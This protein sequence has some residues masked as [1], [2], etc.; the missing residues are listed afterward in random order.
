MFNLTREIRNIDWKVFTIKLL[1]NTLILGALFYFLFSFWEVIRQEA[2]FA[3]WNIRGQNFTVDEIKAEDPPVESPFAGLIRQP[4]PLKVTPESTQFGIV[5]EKIGV[6][7]PVIED[8]SVT[9]KKAYLAALENGVAHA[10][11][12]AKP[13]Q[14]GNAYLF[15][16]SALDFWN[17]GPYS[18][19]FNLL[20]K[21]EVGDRIVIFYN[22]Q[23]FDYYVTNKEVV[24][25]FNTEPL[26][27]TFATPYLTLQTCDPPGIALNRLIITAELRQP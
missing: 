11:G 8:V 2:L 16:H 9:D 25:G 27:R 7:A 6:N 5:I 26:I 20:R 22:E 1:S 4:T 18:G 21:L 3:F 12:T 17:Y 19:V 23:R 15:A 14:I 24:S 13:G 10:A